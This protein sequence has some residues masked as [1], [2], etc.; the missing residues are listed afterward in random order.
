MTLGLV[1]CVLLLADA[2]RLRRR[3]RGV[4]TLP[5]AG[6]STEASPK[7]VALTPD[8]APLPDSL[9]E[10]AAEMM[11]REAID[12][13]DL[14]PGHWGAASA[15]DFLRVTDTTRPRADRLA[16]NGTAGSALVVTSELARRTTDLPFTDGTNAIA[17]VAFLRRATELR[18]CARSMAQVVAPSLAAHPLTAEARAAVLRVRMGPAAQ[19][20]LGI[21]AVFYALVAV[22]FAL[23][24][25]GGAIALLAF[26]LQPSIA[27]ARAPVRCRDLVRFTLLRTPIDIA[28]WLGLAFGGREWRRLRNEHLAALRRTYGELLRDGIAPFFEPRAAQCPLCAS[29]SL[30]PFLTSPERIQRKPGLFALERCDEC[31]HIFQNPRLSLAGLAFYYRDFYDGLG[32]EITELVFGLDKMPY[33]VRAQAM[34][35]HAA[36]AT[37]LDVGAGHGHFCLCAREVFPDT[38]FDGLEM[39]AGVDLALRRGWMDRGLRGMFP[40]QVHAIEGTYDVVSMSHYLEHARDP[41]AEI[42]AARVALRPGGH[43]LIEVPDPS[44]RMGR[45][46]RSYWMPW[47]QPQHLHFV[48]PRRCEALLGDAGFEVVQM[49]RGE[50]H[51]PID[52]G[53]AA[54]LWLRSVA[55]PRYLPWRPPESA[56]SRLRRVLGLILGVP[57]L[58][59]GFLLDRLIGGWLARP[60]WSNGFRVIARRK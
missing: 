10:S 19:F 54:F 2:L 37:W 18:R 8:G 33:V 42:A 7:V 44:S 57:L 30:A 17:E 56:L 60:G 23:N 34:T 6:D 22:A 9:L 43:L 32:A 58:V 45:I 11:R 55:P 21:A 5:A 31:G 52:F 24:T 16:R 3:W 53:A 47:F 4:Q 20:V 25:W 27:L 38:R 50:A 59:C 40:E 46:L 26:H 41:R 49:Q 35:A 1:L 14:V 51:G 15:F 36:P 12:V 48:D 13:L 29:A 39:G 28:R